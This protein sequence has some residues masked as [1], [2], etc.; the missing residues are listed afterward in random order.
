MRKLSG[1]GRY[2]LMSVA[3]G[4]GAMAAAAPAP[5]QTASA[6]P[7]GYTMSRTGSV[8]DFDYFAGA[9]LTHQRKLKARGVGS[10]DWEEFPATLC[11][12][13][14]LDGAA[15]VDE[16]YMPTKHS[17][18]LTLRTFDPHTHQWSIYWINS[19][20][21]KIDPVPEVGG[22]DGDH[23]EFYAP[24]VDAGRPV[25]TRYI[26]TKINHDHARWE[27]AFSFDDKTWETNWIGEFERADAAQLCRNG[28][29]KR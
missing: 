3:I 8:H 25:K 28:Q 18:G 26:W 7:P 29:P 21:G 10:N 22:F 4:M 5:A 23:G 17:A 9:W 14:Y 12:T 15:N 24:D 27:Q 19:T 20:I 13:T 11:M 2:L 16:L 1:S 6:A